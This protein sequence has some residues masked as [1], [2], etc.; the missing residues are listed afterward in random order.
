MSQGEPVNSQAASLIPELSDLALR[1]PVWGIAA[2]CY[3][4]ARRLDL[5]TCTTASQAEVS[6]FCHLVR[7]SRFMC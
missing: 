4:K 2:L 1:P 6:L 3:T 5:R 7:H